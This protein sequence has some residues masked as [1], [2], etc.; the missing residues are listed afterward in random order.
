M[1]G[2][3]FG[4]GYSCYTWAEGTC[5]KGRYPYTDSFAIVNENF[6]NS[7]EFS[8]YIQLWCAG[9]DVNDPLHLDLMAR[10]ETMGWEGEQEYND[11]NTTES[12]GPGLQSIDYYW[13]N[14]A[15]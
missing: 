7:Y 13:S 4:T 12:E 1:L 11:Y 2:D 3:N 5:D 9:N 6:A 15:D 14:V 8:Y 10:N